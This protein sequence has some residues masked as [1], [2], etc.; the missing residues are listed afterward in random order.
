MSVLN[1]RGNI[2]IMLAKDSCWFLHTKHFDSLTVCFALSMNYAN[3]YL[4]KYLASSEKKKNFCYIIIRN[5]WENIG[6]KK[7]Y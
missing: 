1:H 6:G 2:A 4:S 5:Y 3:I 7:A